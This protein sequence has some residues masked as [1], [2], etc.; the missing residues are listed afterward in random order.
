[1]PLA[2]ALLA[3]ALVLRRAARGR[4]RAQHAR[5]TLVCW[6]LALSL[7]PALAAAEPPRRPALHWT[8]GP[9]ATSCI[10]SRALAARVEALTGRVFVTPQDSDYAIEGHVDARRGGGFVVRLAVS[11]HGA[12]AAGERVLEHADADCRALDQGLAFVIALTIDPDLELAALVPSAGLGEHSPDEVLLQ[13]LEAQPPRPVPPPA[14]APTPAQPL[15]PPAPPPERARWELALGALYGASELPEPSLGAIANVIYQGKRWLAAQAQLRSLSTLRRTQ[16]EPDLSMRSDAFATA[17]LACA[18]SA[19]WRVLIAGACAGPEP[20]L[21]AAH[22][23][24]FSE[25]R[26]ARFLLWGVLT[27]V[28]ARSPIGRGWNLGLQG[29]VRVNLQTKEL[30]YSR[31]G[32]SFTAF[33]TPHASF[34]AALSLGYAFGSGKRLAPVT[35][36]QDGRERAR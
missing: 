27:S 29:F 34:G 30:V 19:L 16:L 4:P 36:V 5:A 6:L 31:A 2:C 10:D 11:K 21:I 28:E 26:S 23:L 12:A 33:E 35:H 18:R 3:L 32:E 1:M 9:A 20:E 8:R 25:E 15:P 22:G 24:G 14:I 13:E 17:I 7:L